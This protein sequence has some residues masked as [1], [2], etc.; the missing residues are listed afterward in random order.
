MAGTCLY[1]VLFLVIFSMTAISKVKIIHAKYPSNIQTIMKMYCH[2]LTILSLITT[3]GDFW[4]TFKTSAFYP[5]SKHMT[6]NNCDIR[7]KSLNRLVSVRAQWFFCCEEE[8]EVLK[9]WQLHRRVWIMITS[10][11]VFGSPEV[12]FRI[13]QRPSWSRILLSFFVNTIQMP[14]YHLVT[15]HGIF[16]PHPLSS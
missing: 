16:H 8:F 15:A 1:L 13:G 5:H 6:L 14:G 7:L 4:L 10:H 9:F 2:I 12:E 11:V 3:V